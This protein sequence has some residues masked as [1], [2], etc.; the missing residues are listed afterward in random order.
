[1]ILIVT[2]DSYMR[3]HKTIE[4]VILFKRVPLITQLLLAKSYI[5][6]F[7][8][9]YCIIRVGVARLVISNHEATVLA[10][11][12]L[13]LTLAERLL[14]DLGIPSH[15]LAQLTLDIDSK[16]LQPIPLSMVDTQHYRSPDIAPYDKP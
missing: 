4:N 10:L 16:Q 6:T 13:P 12:E 3:H 5:L 8:V 2:Y 1:M 11:A 7:T 9:E 14:P 15:D